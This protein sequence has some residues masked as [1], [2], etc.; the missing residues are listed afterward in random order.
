MNKEFE[1]MELKKNN[2]INNIDKNI[3][4]I[5]MP[6]R[7][8]IIN[9]FRLNYYNIITIYIFFKLNIVYIFS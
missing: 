6:I 4:I 9:K 2:R 7:K 1:L 8:K 3:Y 5:Y